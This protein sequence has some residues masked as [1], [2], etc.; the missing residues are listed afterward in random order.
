MSEILSSDEIDELLDAIGPSS[1]GESD[2]IHDSRKIKIYDFKR[3]DVFSKEQIRTFR[4][5]G[6]MFSRSLSTLFSKNTKKEVRVYLASVDQ[7]TYEEFIR[8][9]P[10]PSEIVKASLWDNKYLTFEVAPAIYSK[11]TGVEFGTRIKT[12][13]QHSRNKDGSRSSELI[14]VQ[15]EVIDARDLTEEEQK[16]WLK[17]YINPVFKVLGDSLEKSFETKIKN[18]KNIEFDNNPMYVEMTKPY[19]MVLLCTLECKIDDAEESIDVC[20]SYDLA[21]KLLIEL[22]GEPEPMN[23]NIDKAAFSQTMVECEVVLGSTKKSIEDVLDFGEGTILELN[24]L[25]GEP[26]DIRIN[27]K[28]L[29]KGEV[30]V[31][32]DNFGVRITGMI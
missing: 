15:T 16:D 4:Y 32:D 2:S 31:V 18:F 17:N 27:G 9:V 19:E 10:T 30:V 12:S 20:F 25:A 11:L 8:C 29:A 13:K 6:D 22:N 26:V 3:P 24:K 5:W 23:K 1:N 14:E 7:L 21:K 28:I